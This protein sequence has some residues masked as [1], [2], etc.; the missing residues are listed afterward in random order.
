MCWAHDDFLC[1]D[2]C[3]SFSDEGAPLPLTNTNLKHARS[4]WGATVTVSITPLSQ[5]VARQLSQYTRTT[6]ARVGRNTSGRC[7]SVMGTRGLYGCTAHMSQIS[8]AL[9]LFAFI[10]M[11]LVISASVGYVRFS[12]IYRLRRN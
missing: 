4:C 6:K 11:L 1:S 7:A 5:R 12:S 3:R 8:R 10:T 2:G 9:L